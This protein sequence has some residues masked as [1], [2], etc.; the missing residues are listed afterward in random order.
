ML[1]IGFLTYDYNVGG[2]EYVTYQHI[3][4]AK[5]LGYSPILISATS[6]LFYEK[7]KNLNVKCYNRKLSSNICL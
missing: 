6:G 2:S 5:Q 3:K 7:T 1:N 4:Y